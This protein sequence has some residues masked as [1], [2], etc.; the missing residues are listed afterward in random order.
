MP[1]FFLQITVTGFYFALPCIIAAGRSKLLSVIF[2]NEFSKRTTVIFLSMILAFV[3]CGIKL[4][5]VATDEKFAA[6]ATNQS[7]R[8]ITLA[9]LRGTVYDCNGYPLTETAFHTVTVVMPTEKGILSLPSLCTDSELPIHLDVLKSGTPTVL[10]GNR[11]EESRDV[12]HVS[13]PIRY[14]GEL[15]HVIG[16]TDSSG[17]GVSG[18]EKGLDSLLYT[19]KVLGISYSVDRAGHLLAGESTE[20]LNVEGAACGVNLT[21]DK[22][23][24]HITEEAMDGIDSGAAVVLDAR[25]GK[26]RAMVSR[27]DFEPTNVAAYLGDSSSPLI[28]RALCPYNVGSVFKPCLAAA[29]IESGLSDFTCSCR[30]G[31]TVGGRYF[32]C[33][34][35]AG[36]GELSLGTALAKSCN[37]FFYEL[38]QALGGER[39]FD[40][41]RLFRFGDGFDLGGG[42]S[43]SAGNLTD[44]SALALNPSL[45]ANLSIGQGDLL[46]SPVGISTLYMAIANGGEY[47]LPTLIE[48]TFKDGK[49]E[50]TETPPP[51]R[52]MDEQT[53]NTLKDQLAN[54]LVS[55][56]GSAAYTEGITAGGK[57]GTA[58]TGWLDGERHILNGWF[59]G[60]AE[61]GENRYVIIILKED[62]KSGSADC[63]P[64]FKCIT[65]GLSAEANTKKDTVSKSLA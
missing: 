55:G 11:G 35:A 20:I 6:A 29:A 16:Y 24:Q 52:V 19:D 59:C 9:K 51:T 7:T 30:G 38:G 3:G 28:N 12:I 14:G 63:A 45:L 65:E 31:L 53:A 25:N 1:R 4:Y 46:L 41:A 21:I 17:H 64:V 48:S 2:L 22:T 54:V 34:S 10:E 13:V 40:T 39:V 61:I 60:Y 36:H 23:V 43:A 50:K 18:I 49:T 56:T 33:N 27:P 8:R 15:C 58:Q 37:C 47:T 26:I 32:K 62:V 57:T 42:I 5:T 44:R